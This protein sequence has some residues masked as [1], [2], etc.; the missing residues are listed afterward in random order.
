MTDKTTLFQ[1]LEYTMQHWDS[2][3]LSTQ[4]HQITSCFADWHFWRIKRWWGSKQPKG[5]Q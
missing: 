4:V 1:R 2:W 5:K 3:P